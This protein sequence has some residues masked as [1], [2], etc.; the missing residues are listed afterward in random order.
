CG[1]Y[2]PLNPEVDPPV[3]LEATGGNPPYTW[4]AGG[5]FPPGLTLTSDGEIIDFPEYESGAT[6]PKEYVFIV[7]VTDSTAQTADKQLSIMV[8]LPVLGIGY[9]PPQEPPLPA[10]LPD[11]YIGQDPEYSTTLIADCAIGDLTWNRIS[12]GLPPGLS[13]GSA[14]GV[15]SGPPTTA[16]TY[17]FTVEVKDE[18]GP[19]T[20]SQEM[21]IRIAEP[22]EIATDSW[23]HSAVV[24]SYYTVTLNAT[25]GIPPLHFA[26]AD[27]IVEADWLS[28]DVNGVI[29]GTPEVTDA[30]IYDFPV[31]VLD[32]SIPP[33]GPVQKMFRVIVLPSAPLTGLV[34]WWPGNSNPFD[35]ISGN[36]G[37][38]LNG[39]TYD[40]G[41]VDDAFSF[42]GVDDYITAPGT[43]IDDLQEFTVEFWVKANSFPSHSDPIPGSVFVELYGEKA[44]LRYDGWSGG[45]GYHYL[46]FYMRNSDNN[47]HHVWVDCVLQTGCYH[48]V[49]GTYDGDI[50]RLYL[51]GYEVGQNPTSG[52]YLDGSGISLGGQAHLN[53]L[54][55]EVKIYNRALVLEE[56]RNN[57]LIAA[58]GKC[59]HPEV[60]IDG[61]MS[62]G[63]WD[64]ALEIGFNVNLPPYG[65][66]GGTTP[67]TLFIMNDNK[68]LYLAVRY[69]QSIGDIGESLTFEF[70]NNGD[71]GP[72]EN[73]DDVIGINPGYFT[74]SFR[75][76]EDPPCTG[77]GS[78]LPGYCAPRDV[79]PG[80]VPPGDNNG[81]G[82]WGNDGTYTAYEA[83]HPL[84]SQDSSHDFSLS[85]GDLLGIRFDLHIVTGPGNS[86]DVT[87]FPAS[88]WLVVEISG[89]GLIETVAGDGTQGFSGDGGPATDAQL[90]VPLGLGV[91]SSGNIFIADTQSN[92]V[93]KVDIATG[94]IITVAG[95]GNTVYNGDNIPATNA[96]IWRPFD[97]AFDAAGNFYIADIHNQ[98]IRK[99]DIN[100]GI[101]TTVAGDGSQGYNGD[102]IPATSAS[103]ER[104]W[105]VTIDTSGNIFIADT[106]NHRIR[107]VD[108]TTGIITTI[109]GNGTAGYNGDNISATSA[110][111][112][113]PADLALDEAGNL[114][115]ADRDNHRIRKVN[116]STGLITT[117]AG[118]GTQT[119]SIDGEGNNSTDDLGDGGLATTATLNFV[120]DMAFSPSGN[121]FI[122]DYNNDR[123]RKV[124][125][126]SGIITTVAGTGTRTGTIDGEGG[127]PIDDLGDGGLALGA[128]LSH[129]AGLAFDS[130][131]NLYIVDVGNLRI[132]KVERGISPI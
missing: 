43:N 27:P 131:G 99:V 91:D 41:M 33:R 26:P 40:A 18:V 7:Q 77:G 25:G 20:A 87:T 8:D 48:H 42:D 70:D 28:I 45:Q 79:H 107:R 113:T 78:H 121:L 21:S 102:D 30:G 16:G 122:A 52:I 1:Y 66:E 123:I 49:A 56:V 127:D 80:L 24:G 116:L 34:S 115:I 114:F 13:L 105:G 31:E 63:E 55:D 83:S 112:N 85:P 84:N 57:Y 60:I 71:E 65:S 103:L 106:N 68:N 61:V 46:H 124:D 109:A 36:H 82:A 119:G 104:P 51:D 37:E 6:Y 53:G 23:L 93:R 89:L 128:S 110:S 76:N 67:G 88:G 86:H 22:L 95:N 38:L 50:M 12:G 54:L 58:P 10:S 117:V 130:A 17:T 108:A 100:T 3:S 4:I 111:L 15:I 90:N 47:L 44:V 39:T 120:D 81:M 64:S 19:R 2:P 5:N 132:R 35:Y 72:R 118:N 11:G 101:I 126:I 32:S 96:S 75:T 73:G 98:R 94:V 62:P 59:S 74:D 92:R 97:V 129:P 69:P 14:T 29:S 125:I 9:P